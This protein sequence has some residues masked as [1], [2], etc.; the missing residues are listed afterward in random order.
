[1]PALNDL[2][3]GQVELYF[4]PIPSSI[5]HIRAGRLLALALTTATRSEALPEVPTMGEFLP[6]YEASTWFGVGAPQKTPVEIGEKLNK[7]INAALA[8]P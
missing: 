3:A 1:V 5:E 6:G 4:D 2:L 7:E 8:D